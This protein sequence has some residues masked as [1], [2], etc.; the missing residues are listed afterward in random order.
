[1]R[2]KTT[3]RTDQR[4]AADRAAIAEAYLRGVP[5][6]QIAAEVGLSAAQVSRDL[7]ILQRE[8]EARAADRIEAHKAAELA[9]LDTLERT[10]WQAWEAST[11]PQKRTRTADRAGAKSAEVGSV[12]RDGNPAFLS[13]VLSCIDRRC[14]I[15][16]VDAPV[17]VN[18]YVQ[19]EAARVSAAT[20]MSLSEAEAKIRAV[21]QGVGYGGR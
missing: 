10:Y 11:Q 1:M 9:K 3:L 6:Y 4:K 19:Q 21:L 17:N 14:K 18:F 13:G 7:G 16:G 8:W 2:D 5:Q 20:G 12:T 15:L